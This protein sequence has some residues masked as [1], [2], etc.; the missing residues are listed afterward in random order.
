MNGRLAS[1]KIGVFRTEVKWHC[2]SVRKTP[3]FIVRAGR[4]RGRAGPPAAIAVSAEHRETPPQAVAT[5]P[6]MPW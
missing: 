6:I 1:V 3:I 5:T 4:V 2:T